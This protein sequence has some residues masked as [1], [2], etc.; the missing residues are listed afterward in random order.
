MY[1]IKGK[2]GAE[3]Q[4]STISEIFLCF[5]VASALVTEGKLGEGRYL[6][7]YTFLGNHFEALKTS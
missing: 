2:K 3:H 7:T 5:V 6:F 1:L 4:N